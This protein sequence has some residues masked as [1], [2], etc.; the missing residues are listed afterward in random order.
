MGVHSMKPILR[1]LGLSFALL[2]PWAQA[3]DLNLGRVITPQELAG[4]NITVYP[5]GI[6]YPAGQGSVALG[7]KVY[8]S[9]CAA[10]HGQ[11]LEGGL[12]GAQL[13]GG[14][15]SLATD[16]PVKT[17]GSYWPYA[18]TLFDYVRRAMPFHAPQSLSNDD[19]YSVSGYI[20]HVNGL[21]PADAKVDGTVLRAVQ[22]PNKDGFFVDNRPDAKNPR[23]MR[24]CQVVE[25]MP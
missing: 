14:K 2:S 6:G 12:L 22:M 21:L 9:T 7:E 19:V 17:V 20:L 1:G 8:Q 16:R 18:S 3:A 15:G 11:K 23:C 4:W 5:D 24:N 13:A 10:C 25:A